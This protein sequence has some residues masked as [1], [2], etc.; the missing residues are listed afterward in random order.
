LRLERSEENIMFWRQCNFYRKT[1]NR[2]RLAHILYDEYI[3]DAALNQI[4][5]DANIRCRIRQRLDEAP[6]DLYDEAQKHIRELM[7][8]DSY[9]RFVEW[10][11]GSLAVVP[12]QKE[13]KERQ[14]LS[15]HE[16][17][18]DLI[19]KMWH[20]VKR[21]V[22]RWEPSKTK[23]T[24]SH[25]GRDFSI[26]TAADV[27][28]AEVRH[29]DEYALWRETSMRERKMKS[30]KSVVIGSLIHRL[31]NIRRPTADGTCQTS[32]ET[33][34]VSPFDATAMTT[35][36]SPPRKPSRCNGRL[37][38]S[39][40]SCDVDFPSN[41]RRRR[42]S[43]SRVD[44]LERCCLDES[45]S[46]SEVVPWPLL[47]QRLGPSVSPSSEEAE[48]YRTTVRPRDIVRRSTSSRRVKNRR[49]IA[50]ESLVN[51]AGRPIDYMTS[52][53]MRRRRAVTTTSAKNVFGGQ[54][55]TIVG[56]ATHRQTICIL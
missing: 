35:S 27:V 9:R 14:E 46:S 47:L 1:D 36:S 19:S 42:R 54:L 52:S 40:L 21:S 37:D 7:R 6:R 5:I 51:D 50:P 33:S 11:V 31:S 44:D 3:D 29:L 49:R 38:A 26:R 45:S 39:A 10:R 15:S 41:R 53:E 25:I 22:S 20:R 17:H 28:D 2:K 34:G 4:N 12:R 48:D 24:K 8:R 32:I 16:E 30:S 18:E 23:T 55:L 13:K 56:N 43:S